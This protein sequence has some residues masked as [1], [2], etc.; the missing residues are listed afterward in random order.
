M[1]DVVSRGWELFRADAARWVVP[2]EISPLELVTLKRLSVMLVRFPPLRAMAWLRLG[3]TLSELGVRG[4][5]TMVQQRLFSRYGLEISPD[6]QVGGG[7]YIAHP[8]GCVLVAESIGDD[9]TVISQ[10][11]FGT[12]TDEEWPRI[13]DRS[14]YGAGARVLGG[15]AVGA[16]AV[17]GANAVVVRDVTAGSTV[18]GIPARGDRRVVVTVCEPLG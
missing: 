15:I 16:D 7:L 12:R 8:I 5:S 14:F 17:V 6:A 9:V 10:V 18:V 3:A 4:V 1:R 11:T 13:G 2:E